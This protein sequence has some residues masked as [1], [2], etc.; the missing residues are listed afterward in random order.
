MLLSAL[1]RGQIARITRVTESDF[2]EKLM[3][4]GCITG[5]LVK[6]TV[7]APLGD[8]VAYDLDGYCLSMRKTEASSIEVELIPAE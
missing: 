3:E 7:T 6:R 2:S 1:K 5:V 8:P 4:M